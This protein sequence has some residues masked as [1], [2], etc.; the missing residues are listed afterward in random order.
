MA[1]E[2]DGAALRL[3]QALEQAQ[4][5]ALAAAAGSDERDLLALADGQ[6][7]TLELSRSP[8]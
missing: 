2:A 3:V 8:E 6:V 5:R 4:D 1:I 7:K